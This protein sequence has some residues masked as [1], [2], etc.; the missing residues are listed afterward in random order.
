MAEQRT[1]GIIL[2]TMPLTETSLIVHWLTPDFGRISTV[3]KGARRAKSSFHGRVDV[4]HTADFTFIES[5][6]SDLHILKEIA[7]RETFPA[8]RRDML[9]LQRAA[10]GS[11][12]IGLATESAT[13]L[14]EIYEQ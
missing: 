8:L 5:R 14:A 6:K 10:Y 3:A 9:L 4:F 1:T 2:R 7:L 12:L 11:A 13:P